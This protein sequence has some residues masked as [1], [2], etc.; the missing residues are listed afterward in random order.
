[1]RRCAICGGRGDV[2]TGWCG[3]AHPTC[4]RCR[5]AI[6]LHY[7]RQPVRHGTEAGR[8][9]WVRE[10]VERR[11]CPVLAGQRASGKERAA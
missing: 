4:E 10:T 6:R 3:S 5:T 9:A 1:M 11:A 7:V 8:R 2:V